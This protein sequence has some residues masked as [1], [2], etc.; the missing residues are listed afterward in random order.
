LA[1]FVGPIDSNSLIGPNDLVDHIGL[2]GLIEPICF[3]DLNSL[4]NQISVDHNQ[5]IVATADTKISLHF[6]KSF[7]IF[8]EGDRE[9]ADNQN[10][11]E[12]DEVFVPQKSNLP[13]LFLLASA[14]SAQAETDASAPSDTLAA[15]ASFGQISPIKL[16]ASGSSNHWCI[17][18]IGVIG[19]GLVGSS[20]SSVFVASLARRLIGSVGHVGLIS[21][22]VGLVGLIV[23]NGHISLIKLIG[24]IG[25]V[26]C[27]GHNGL[28]GI[29]GLSFVSLAS[30]VSL[31]V[32]SL[33]GWS[34]SSAHHLIIFFVL[35]SLSI[36]RPFKQAAHG[37]AI[38]LTNITKIANAVSI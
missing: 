23:I 37:V 21:M 32:I 35:V 14:I 20:A 5:L 7:A 34:A 15:T 11:I 28:V 22:I 17:G 27:I 24:Y 6:R 19:V 4:F 1:S 8:R 26:G 16:L 9:N 10:V 13:S 36:H 30:K 25:L 33:V 3:V 29:I 2:I 12:D 38:K 18:L 31:S